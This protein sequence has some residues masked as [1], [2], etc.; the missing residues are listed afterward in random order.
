VA[1][2]YAVAGLTVLA[3]YQAADPDR[4]V[5]EVAARSAGG[6]AALFGVAMFLTLVAAAIDPGAFGVLSPLGRPLAFAGEL[7][8]RYVLGPPIAAL[9]WLLGALVPSA[10]NPPEPD[11]STNDTPPPEEDREQALWIRALA[12]I[13]VAGSVALALL[14]ALA[15]LW[16]ILRRF[17][18]AG[19]TAREGDETA[20]TE[21]M[22]LDDVGM[23][24]DGFRRRFMRRPGAP[25]SAIAIRRLYTD[26]LDRA[27][28]DGLERP[29]TATPAEFAPSLDARYGSDAGTAI[30]E[31]FV[32][33]RYGGHHLD[34]A[35]VRQL[36]DH[37]RTSWD[38]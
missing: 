6:F 4:K 24:L 28:A 14:F 10:G 16:L 22:L 13:A 15:V 36:R 17:A 12:Y 11:F 21:S 3:M 1:F 33:S 30:T 29:V 31:A 32:S 26:M 34:E 20:E 19:D 38:R 35:S 8:G 18:R 23:L 25:P 7:I 37:W 2:A 5:S 27:A 9:A